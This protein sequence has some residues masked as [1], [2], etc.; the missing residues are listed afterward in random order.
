MKYPRRSIN[1]Q[2]RQEKNIYWTLKDVLLPSPV[3]ALYSVVV[4]QTE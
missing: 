1:E 2:K 4:A 3:G